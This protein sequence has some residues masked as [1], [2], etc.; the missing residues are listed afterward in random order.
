LPLPQVC[1]EVHVPHELTV[2]LLPQLSKFA[3]PPQ[4]LPSREQKAVSV[5]GVQ[6]TLLLPHVCGNVQVPHEVTVRV[7][8][9]L[10]AVV[11]LPQIASW[12][13]QKAVSVSGM[14]PPVPVAPPVP[15]VVVSLLLE[16]PLRTT[17]IPR[18]TL[19]RIVRIPIPPAKAMAD[20][21]DPAWHQVSS[22]DRETVN[23]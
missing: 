9:Q 8:P 11:K 2:R 1:G 19:H 15:S 7:V 12:P 17:A 20:R 6:Q 3:T 5:S 13:R 16:H 23:R 18:A 21:L 10:S 22:Q 14:Q 4:C